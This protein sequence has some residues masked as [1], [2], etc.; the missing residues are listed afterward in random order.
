LI[1]IGFIA[2]R[3]NK[4]GITGSKE[5]TV[6]VLPLQSS[7]DSIEREY[8]HALSDEIA[9]SLVKVPGVRVMSQR[10]IAA[11]REQ[12]DADPAKTR[13]ALGADFHV[14]G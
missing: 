8:A 7:G 4:S 12:R 10:G 6:A 5:M 14:I 2:A 13:R 9:T 1:G 11:S 3:G